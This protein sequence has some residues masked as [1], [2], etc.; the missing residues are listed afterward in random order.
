MVPRG[1]VPNEPA[2]SE[3]ARER[4]RPGE[5]VTHSL[6]NNRADKLR[7]ARRSQ[8]RVCGP[9]VPSGGPRGGG[10]RPT[11]VRAPQTPARPPPPTWAALLG[12][13]GTMRRARRLPGPE[14]R[15]PRR[16]TAAAR[17]WT[18]RLAPPPRRAPQLGRGP[19]LR[20]VQRDPSSARPARRP[21]LPAARA[22]HPTFPIKVH[23][24]RERGLR[25][26]PPFS[27][28]RRRLGGL[29]PA[30][31]LG[32]ARLGRL[33]GLAAR[34]SPGGLAVPPIELV[35]LLR[36]T[37]FFFAEAAS[38]PSSA[39]LRIPPRLKR[40]GLTPLCPARSRLP[41]RGSGTAEGAGRREAGRGGAADG[42]SP[43]PAAGV[44]SRWRRPEVQRRGRSW[45]AS[46]FATSSHSRAQPRR[47]REAVEPQLWWADPGKS[48]EPLTPRKSARSP[49]RAVPPEPRTGDNEFCERLE[50]GPWWNQSQPREVKS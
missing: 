40:V 16:P 9:D 8:A 37:F 5:Q 21:R 18:P 30:R 15:E 44:S 3:G 19:G 43:R 10:E 17:A 20:A 31:A 45:V 22:L 25:L 26:P 46:G 12:T 33:S 23:F 32:S 38:A 47:T 27:S 7:G 11:R 49:E 39:R 36:R 28:R 42:Q 41:R 29:G 14:P 24:G 50:P 1:G 6:G 34:G 13:R 4:R 35:G 2:P 48:A